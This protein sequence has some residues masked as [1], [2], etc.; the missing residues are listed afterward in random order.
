MYRMGRVF[1]LEALSKFEAKKNKHSYICDRIIPQLSHSNSAVVMG[2]IKVIIKFMQNDTNKNEKYCKKLCQPL[3]TLIS[4]PPEIQYV[5]LRNIDL[6]IQKYP[7][8]FEN[9]IRISNNNI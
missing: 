9:D 2:A 5:A 6:I 7:K 4:S 1:I 8:I 3:L